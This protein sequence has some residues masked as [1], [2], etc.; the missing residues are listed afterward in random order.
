[1]N[2]SGLIYSSPDSGSL[3]ALELKRAFVWADTCTGSSE[4]M[5]VSL[6][7]SFT[8]TALGIVGVIGAVSGT[9][10]VGVVE[11][12]GLLDRESGLKTKQGWL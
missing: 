11:G 8:A 6:T 12:W 1:M 10:K 2:S 4:P 3:T 7:A 9:G 5:R